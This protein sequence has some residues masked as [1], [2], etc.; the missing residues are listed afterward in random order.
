MTILFRRWLPLLLLA[1]AFPQAA[2]AQD[3]IIT[4]TAS[5]PPFDE[6]L[7]EQMNFKKEN[8]FDVREIRLGSGDHV[9]FDADGCVN[10]GGLGN[11][12]Y[13][14]VDPVTGSGKPHDWYYGMVTVRGTPF[15]QNA[16]LRFILGREF[17]IT[18][19]GVLHVDYK[20]NNYGD[21]HNGITDPGP[22]DQCRGAGPARLRVRVRRGGPPAPPIPPKDYDLVSSQL[23]GNGLLLNPMFHLQVV[24]G[25]DAA[26]GFP[27]SAIYR[28]E[29]A[30]Y[31]PGGWYD[32][33]G[34]P[35]LTNQGA[36]PSQDGGLCA[37]P[38]SE[39]DG[40]E[41]WHVVAAGDYLSHV[42]YFPV[43]Y[44]TKRPSGPEPVSEHETN[45]NVLVGEMDFSVN[46]WP[47][48]P[49]AGPTYKMHGETDGWEPS[50]WPLGHT[51]ALSSTPFWNEVWDGTLI[52]PPLKDKLLSLEDRRIFM[53]GLFNIDVFHDHNTGDEDQGWESHPVFAL[54]VSD[55]KLRDFNETVT[56][57]LWHVLVRD[58]GQGGFCDRETHRFSFD[59]DDQGTGPEFFTFD[60]PV[61]DFNQRFTVSRIEIIGQALA[62]KN[63]VVHRV[64]SASVSMVNPRTARLRLTFD[65]SFDPDNKE[66]FLVEG[67]IRVRYTWSQGHDL[68][69]REAAREAVCLGIDDGNPCTID[70][71]DP[72]T[73][74]VP[75]TPVA[76][77]TPCPDRNVCNGAEICRSGA[78]VRDPGVPFPPLGTSCS[79][80]N[81]CNGNETCDGAG[82]C[83]PGK[84]VTAGR[85]PRCTYVS[86][87]PETGKILQQPMTPERC[88]MF[89]AEED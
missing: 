47:Y 49:K 2:R 25:Q 24:S 55:V 9:T 10:R 4:Q 51:A 35:T 43:S 77:G 45:P 81:A 36:R 88:K 79:D 78:C 27:G 11:T 3:Y 22:A 82:L 52:D 87:D 62:L 72:A 66:Y 12:C 67:D 41:Y 31:G 16:Q 59:R 85:I 21:N 65:R 64:T 5:S 34:M 28:Y 86:C 42:T 57:E 20:D 46:I 61:E 1:L 60:L 32:L 40:R 8:G 54:A 33:A 83:R 76:D 63:P 84:P 29:Q 7:I 68:G 39:I 48:P 75:G 6:F 73:G 38:K 69:V 17:D 37:K 53:T 18:R 15:L 71:C 89:E 19:F 30:Y 74:T 56:E 44:V 70:T 50:R 26:T 23:D 13:R 80:D 58:R 14:W